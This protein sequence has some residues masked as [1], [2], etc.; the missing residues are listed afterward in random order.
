MSPPG[1]F[2]TDNL[3]L[4]AKARDL[5]DEGLSS[6]QIGLRIGVTK[7]AIIGIAHRRGWPARPNPIERGY[8]RKAKPARLRKPAGAGAKATLP[9]LGAA[10]QPERKPAPIVLN[11]RGP[12]CWPSGDKPIRFECTSPARPGRPY[13]AKHCAVSYVRREAVA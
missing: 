13:C 12:C 2:W 9:S 5:W 7:N 11:S 8:A 1:G 10:S 6:A 3:E 4:V